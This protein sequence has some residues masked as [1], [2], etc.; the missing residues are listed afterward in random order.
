MARSQASGWVLTTV[1]RYKRYPGLT[2]RPAR[3]ARLL[4]ERPR[5]ESA[6]RDISMLAY[7]ASIVRGQWPEGVQRWEDW[8]RALDLEA[9]AGGP[10]RVW[11][12]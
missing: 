5:S 4:L 10:R 3:I 2:P 12:R 7:A 8:D 1:E 6:G 9:I 11:R